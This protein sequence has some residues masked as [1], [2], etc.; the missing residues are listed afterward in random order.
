M[1][2][3]PPSESGRPFTHW[4]QETLAQAAI[5]NGIVK[6]ISRHSVGRFLREAALKPHLSEGWINTP[7][8]ADFERKCRDACATYTL[9]LQ[10]AADGIETHSID[11][12]TGVQ[13]LERAA[14]T[15]LMCRKHAERTEFEY[16]RH[17]TTTL[18]AHFDVATG[19]VGYHLGPTRTEEDFAEYLGQLLATR[20]SQTTWHLVMDN[21]NI[22]CS[23]AA[24]R[25]VAEAIGFEGDLGVKGIF[26]QP[27]CPRKGGSA[28]QYLSHNRCQ[29]RGYGS[30]Y[31]ADVVMTFR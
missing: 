2:C 16:I 25:L 11:E 3:E 15:R 29:S 22:H 10:R 13:A 12:M 19:Q 5:E 28:T 1:A 23:E 9:A 20:P 7:R 8:D 27:R 17:G 14:P 30:W 18:I 21:L 24:V 6:D 4:T 26:H 31:E